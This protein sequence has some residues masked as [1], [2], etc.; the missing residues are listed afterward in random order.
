[1]AEIQMLVSIQAMELTYPYMPP[2]DEEQ[3]QTTGDRSSGETTLDSIPGPRATPDTTSEELL[4][5]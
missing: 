3:L 2:L 4:G 1:M 5:V